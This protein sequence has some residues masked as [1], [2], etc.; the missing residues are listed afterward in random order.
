MVFATPDDLKKAIREVPN[1]PKPGIL[2]Y[3]LTTLFLNPP[4]FRKAMD[5]LIYRYIGSRPDVFV[6]VEARGFLIAS[7]LAY[8]LGTGVVVARK[9]GKLPYKTRRVSYSLEYGT[10]ELEIHED[11]IQP[12]QRV[13]ILD[14]LLATGGT[15]EAAATLVETLGG[16]VEELACIVELTFL[17]GRERLKKYAVHSLISYDNEE[18]KE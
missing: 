6:G 16:K 18:V 5:M 2:F 1:F 13:V 3:D 17:P 9:P 7:A 10:A 11:A 4:A 14:D 12:G 15:M 8:A